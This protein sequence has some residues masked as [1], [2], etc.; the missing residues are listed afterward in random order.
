MRT[1]SYAESFIPNDDD[2]AMC[3][4]MAGYSALKAPAIPR[5]TQ[6]CS[7]S[8]SRKCE[9]TPSGFSPRDR[10]NPSTSPTSSAGNPKRC[11]PVS[12]LTWNGGR[13]AAG[14]SASARSVSPSATAAVRPHAAAL[15][16]SS[17]G[18]TAASTGRVRPSARSASPSPTVATPKKSAYGS[19]ARATSR[20]PCP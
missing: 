11:I 10:K 19:A 13:A 15:A 7:S 3:A 16:S 2:E 5:N 12:N 1:M 18:H 8:G 14:I 4:V 20:M 17:A 6:D 9:Y